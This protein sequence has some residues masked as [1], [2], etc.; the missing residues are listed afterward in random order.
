MPGTKLKS[1][2]LVNFSNN[3]D[4]NRITSDLFAYRDV[5][6]NRPNRNNLNSQM[7]I[8]AND[9]ENTI[10]KKAQQVADYEGIQILKWS[11]KDEILNTLK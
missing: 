1:E 7:L 5:K 6:N 2:K 10:S 9:L 8:I 11:N 4:Y 3:L